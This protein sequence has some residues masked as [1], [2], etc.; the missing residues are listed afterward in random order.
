MGLHSLILIM[1]YFCTCTTQSQDPRPIPWQFNLY[2]AN[3]WLCVSFSILWQLQHVVQLQFSCYS[4]KIPDLTAA[5]IIFHWWPF[6]VPA[7]NCVKQS[8]HTPPRT[9][10]CVV[11][12]CFFKQWHTQGQ[13]E[14]KKTVSRPRYLGLYETPS[15][16]LLQFWSNLTLIN[17]MWLS[18]T[19]DA[20]GL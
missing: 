14:G 9:C 11:N 20:W 18:P 8:M 16:E 7:L 1:I 15:A 13:F 17:S 5:F 6:F 10:H 3:N 2:F 12:V 4:T 19:D